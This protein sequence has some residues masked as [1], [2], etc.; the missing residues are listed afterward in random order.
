MS[1]KLIH[2]WKKHPLADLFPPLSNEEQSELTS[3]IAKRG[4]IDSTIWCYENKILDG[5]GRF[6]ACDELGTDPARN[7]DPIFTEYVGDDPLGFVISKNVRRRHL[8]KS[9]LAMCAAKLANLPK[10]R[11]KKNPQ[12]YGFSQEDA[13][14][15]FGI[16]PKLVELACRVLKFAV[17]E[18]REAID[19]GVLMINAAAQIATLSEGQQR[20]IMALGNSKAILAAI[21]EHLPIARNEMKKATITDSKTSNPLAYNSLFLR[22]IG[23]T[24]FRIG[25]C[26]LFHGD[27]FKVMPELD[28]GIDAMISDPP[29]GILGQDW[30]IKLSLDNFWEIVESKIKPTANVVL[31]AGG[32]FIPR[33]INSN[34]PWHRYELIWEKN[35]RG[36]HLNAHKQPMRTHEQIL[37][38]GRPGYQEVTT[39]NPVKCPSRRRSSAL[40][41]PGSIL[42]CPK[43]WNTNL[44]P[45][46]KPVKLMEWLIRTY[47]NEGD[48]VIDPFMGSGTTALAA[49]RTNRRFIGIE[50]DKLF[51]D[52]AVDRLKEKYRPV[53]NV[54]GEQRVKP[55]QQT[56]PNIHRSG[57][58]WESEPALTVREHHAQLDPS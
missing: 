26:T 17:P 35:N 29:F 55:Q 25:G 9:Q 42:R 1:K 37:V 39:Y 46:Q 14:R 16:S 30:D 23:T 28:D 6:M 41:H 51:F 34:L 40:I 3:D 7:I 33:L 24:E 8:N 5:W 36:N 13:A 54:F 56:A 15:R 52:R 10:G 21:K 38:F 18:I 32:K 49:I 44:H 57:L 22:N 50:N 31:F 58:L 48:L 4:L 45:T 43:D 53:A 27:S 47:T 12:I 2:R 19:A 20:E 11:P